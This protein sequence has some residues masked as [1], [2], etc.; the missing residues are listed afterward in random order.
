ML[1]IMRRKKRLKVI[2]WLVIFSLALGMLLFFVPGINLGNV[3]TDSSAAS[4]DGKI[5]PMRDYIA[6][7]HRL[8]KRYSN[9]G[10]NKT[11]PETLKALGISK[12]VLDELV[13]SKVIEVIAERFGLDVT[14]SEVRQA[15]ETA[16]YLQDQGKFIGI[17][18]YKAL[19]AA[20]DL[21]VEEFEGDMRN[22]QLQKKVRAIITDALDVTDS[23]L[24]QDFSKTNQQTQV[25]YAFLKKD[26]FKKRVKPTDADLQAYFDAH[27]ADYQIKEKR[28]AQY[29]LVPFSQMLAGVKVTDQEL[30]DEW[31]KSPHEETVEAAHIL[32]KVDDPSKDAE[33]KAKAEGVLKQLKS[34]GDFA[35]LAKKHSQDTGSA[36]QGGY[37]PPF[38]RGQMV[39]EFEDAAFSLK[40]GETSGL[41]HTQF[42]YHIIRVMRHETPTLEANRS[43][44]MMNLRVKKAQEL[45]KAKAEEAEKIVEKSKDLASASKSLG[46]SLEIKETALFQKD[47]NAFEF[48]ISPA[49]R[50]EAFRLKEINSIGKVVEHPLGYAIPKLIE[51]QLPKPGDFAQSRGKVEQDCAE[52]KA[53]ELM[54]AEAKKLSE[55]ARAQGNFEKAAKEMGLTVKTSQPFNISGTPDPEIGANSE[56]TKV[57][58][59]L[60][61]GGVSEPLPMFDKVM[62]FQVKSRTPFDEAAFQKQKSELRDRTLQSSQDAFFEDYVRQVTEELEKSGKI[63]QNLK[64]IENASTGSY[65]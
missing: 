41:V 48:A 62:V 25:V 55:T 51:V 60:E 30:M 20:N 47:A 16:S 32:L 59:A 6:A 21:T 12:R 28:K 63:R 22:A 58:F 45:A 61:P 14:P 42:G 46:M 18:R 49:L 50:D 36:A 54:E 7:Y 29:L 26:D 39:K 23:E 2:L 33:I 57:A 24:R 31:S 38:S 8:V 3:T 53:K 56:F 13:A 17:E 64:A 44:L 5:I 40:P 65:Y 27:K 9:N 11:D 37:L 4:V 35:E 43:S 34:G 52:S 1:D 10:K 19:L 15:I